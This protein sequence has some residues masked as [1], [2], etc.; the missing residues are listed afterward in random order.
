MWELG[1]GAGRRLS[2]YVADCGARNEGL[3][4]EGCLRLQQTRPLRPKHVHGSAAA[5]AHTGP[6]TARRP[7]GLARAVQ[8]SCNR[9]RAASGSLGDA[10]I[11]VLAR[12]HT[13]RA[14][15]ARQPC[16]SCCM[17]QKSPHLRACL[18]TFSA[19]MMAP[20][21]TKCKN[22]RRCGVWVPDWYLQDICAC[23]CV[24]VRQAGS[25]RIRT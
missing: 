20:Q 17:T 22:H 8:I 15:H 12:V 4:W 3:G 13:A 24:C 5:L 25:A 2:A 10:R 14:L 1:G 11:Q 21:A 19:T 16:L 9:A 18:P 23:A 6:G 7:A